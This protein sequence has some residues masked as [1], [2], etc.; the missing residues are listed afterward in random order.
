ML[1]EFAATLSQLCHM[2][3]LL[4]LLYGALLL[5]G[6]VLSQG[7]VMGFVKGGLLILL[8]SWF[9]GLAG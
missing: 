9:A 2:A 4:I 3:G 8:G 7:G 5:I 1:H 6:G